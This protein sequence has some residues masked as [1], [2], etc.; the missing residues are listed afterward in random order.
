MSLQYTLHTN[1]QT[2]TGQ[3]SLKSLTSISIPLH[4]ETILS[5][6]MQT[7]R[8]LKEDEKVYLNGFQSWSWSKPY[9]KNDKEVALHH[10]PKSMMK[11]Y[12][13]DRYG[14]AY[15]T[16]YPK[17]KGIFIGYSFMYFIQKDKVELFA[18]LNEDN[19]Y[20]RFVYDANT[21]ALTIEK[22]SAGLV[23]DGDYHMLDL[24]HASG[25]MDE[26]F[27]GWFE[28]LHIKPRT[29]TQIAG[30]SSWYNHYQNI[31]HNTIQEDLQG[32][33]TLLQKG[34]MFQIDDGWET[35]VGDWLEVDTKK[36]PNGLEDEI[37]SIHNAGYQAGLWLAPFVAEKNSYIFQNHPSWFLKNAEGPWF[38]G[39]NWSGFY[40][41]DIDN[42]EVIEY[43]KKVFH[44]VFDV[45]HI[46][47]VKLD[48]LYAVAPFNSPTETRAK[49]MHRAMKLLR[50]LCENHLIL[51]C[52]VPL[53]P[54]FGL[55]DY[56]RIGTDVSL[57]WDSTWWWRLLH[58]ERT[59]TSHAI[60][61]VVARYPLHNR[62]WINDPDVFFLRTN[63][64]KLSPLTK[65]HMTKLFALLGGVFFTSDNMGKYGDEQKADYFYARN[66]RDY[67]IDHIDTTKGIHIDA[68]KGD[69]Y[70]HEYLFYKN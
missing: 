1:H 42:P 20:T 10:V 61:M 14:D 29:I 8:P 7:T 16:T 23:V 52:G 27:D 70:I 34:D 30:Y 11:K 35:F 66:L 47:L 2:Y 22:D 28:I 65:K 9:T 46:D 55:V 17:R 60:D 21:G 26:V 32:A 15:F 49:R 39:C 59:S 5:T 4:N 50:E 38:A 3:T 40:S 44:I 6:S 56:C 12:G 37:Q 57:D 19:G 13:F 18:S 43:L 64:T 54:S 36:F 33:T 41:L 53:F 25:S 63:N 67:Q 62:G 48:F 45:W 69:K 68:H 24:Y 51:G 58:K 31:S